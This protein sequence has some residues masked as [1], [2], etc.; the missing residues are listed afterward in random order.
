M[1]L[2]SAREHPVHSSSPSPTTSPSQRSA[3]VG[4]RLEPAVFELC[5]RKTSRFMA[6][7][8]L[9]LIALHVFSAL[10]DYGF[11]YERQG[12]LRWLTSL[13]M[14][15]N[16][17]TWYQAISVFVCGV[18][19]LG[20]GALERAR[21]AAR[22]GYWFSVAALFFFLSMDEMGELHERMS[23]PLRK[24][25]GSEGVLL[26]AW[27]LGW[28]AALVVIAITHFRWLLALPAA[29]RGRFLLAGVLFVTGAIGGELVES[30]IFSRHQTFHHLGYEVAVVIE[31]LLEM[32]G[33]LLFT[34]ALLLHLSLHAREL[35][36]RF[37][38]SGSRAVSV[39]VATRSEPR[40]RSRPA[41]E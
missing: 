25:F 39:P 3:S 4:E 20:I 21:A 30:A 24:L 16:P 17:Q 32:T 40:G 35:T 29:T 41:L 36:F 13:D 5:A 12:G 23:G 11:G 6:C 14:E 22:S 9:T 10:L 7:T 37:S 15:Q 33:I 19:L 34:R 8:I 2:S 26:Y 31:E 38:A 1:T 28:G 27:V 18:L